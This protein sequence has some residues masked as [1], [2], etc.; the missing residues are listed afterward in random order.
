MPTREA[1]SFPVPSVLSV[2]K[3]VAYYTESGVCVSGEKN[4]PIL[5]IT[6]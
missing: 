3:I 6:V 1:S 2:S 5:S 4:G